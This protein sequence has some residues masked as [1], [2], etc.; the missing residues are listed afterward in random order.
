MPGRPRI[1]IADPDRGIQRLLQRTFGSA[2]FI[3]TIT[4]TA[5]STVTRI[6]Q[7][8]PDLIV[9]SA[10][11]EDMS[12]SELVIR[13]RAETAAPIIALF[14]PNGLSTTRDLL[15]RG[16]D[17]CVEKPFL[18]E[19]LAARAR[20]LLVRAGVW[21]QPHT[22]PTVAGLITIDPLSRTVQLNERS[23]DLTNREFELLLI[24]LNADGMPV[25]HGEVV[26]R[27]WGKRQANAQQN[28]RRVVGALRARIEY[29]PKRP[30]VLTNIRGLGYK[31]EISEKP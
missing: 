22:I 6:A 17:D 12:G 24:L 25:S 28:L 15:D 9:M 19:E 8:D 4:H 31:L 20:R 11:F 13:A 14:Y 1:L 5:V 26:R 27:I 3:V 7:T 16:A 2:G 21:L 29:N 30:T 10:E 18:V 23:L